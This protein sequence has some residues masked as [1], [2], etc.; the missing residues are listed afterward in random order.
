MLEIVAPF[1]SAFA[2]QT[3]KKAQEKKKKERITLVRN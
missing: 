1:C 2:A 3:A